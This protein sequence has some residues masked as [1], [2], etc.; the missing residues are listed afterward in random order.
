MK[1]KKWFHNKNFLFQYEL[2]PNENTQAPVTISLTLNDELQGAKT[3]VFSCFF[4]PFQ[5]GL[6]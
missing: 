6:N 2:A 5:F 3:S 4:G 1:K